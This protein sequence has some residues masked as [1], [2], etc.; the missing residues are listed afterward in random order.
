MS[1]LSHNFY[2]Y[3]KLKKIHY[4]IETIKIIKKV[5]INYNKAL[6]LFNMYKF[7]RETMKNYRRYGRAK[8]SMKNISFRRE[9]IRMINEG[10]R[11]ESDM[12]D[13]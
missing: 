6:E 12:K 3:M 9:L 8:K 7:Y 11:M 4:G 1:V 10:T 5:P 2:K 13:D